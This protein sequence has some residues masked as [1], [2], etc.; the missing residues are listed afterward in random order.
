MR[1]KHSKDS[2]NPAKNQIVCSTSTS[3]Q[4][5]AIKGNDRPLSSVRLRQDS[6]SRL[7]T[8][9]S[10]TS[11]ASK[12]HEDEN[13]NFLNKKQH[14]L[15]TAKT[16]ATA[17][18]KHQKPQPVPRLNVVKG[19]KKEQANDNHNRTISN[20]HST[21]EKPLLSASKSTRSVSGLNKKKRHS[22][23][24]NWFGY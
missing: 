6:S 17:D 7:Q 20:L 21:H 2:L 19:S 14:R 8:D 4:S 3:L 16:A 11:L 22:E 10:R 5:T 24:Q 1:S 23:G 12:G 13:N 18:K 15:F 9:A